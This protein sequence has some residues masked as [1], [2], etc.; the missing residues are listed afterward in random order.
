MIT[1][2]HP[3]ALTRV[4]RPPTPAAEVANSPSPA[5]VLRQRTRLSGAAIT[6]A[7]APV[8]ELDS[9]RWLSVQW[10]HDAFLARLAMEQAFA[11]LRGDAL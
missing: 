1:P 8:E 3:D 9:D 11:V 5:G 6:G 2:T 7:V 10:L 4:P